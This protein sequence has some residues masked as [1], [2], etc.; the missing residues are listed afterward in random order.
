MEKYCNNCGNFG[1][2]YRQCKHPVL[3]YGIILFNLEKDKEP[4]IV[5]IERKDSISYIEFL[6]GKYQSIYSIDY[7]LLLFSRFTEKE[8]KEVISNDFDT[9][10]RNLWIHTDT[11]NKNVKKEYRNSFEKFNKLKYGFQYKNKLINLNYLVSEIKTDYKMNEWEIPKGRRILKESNKECAIREFEEE[12]NISKDKFNIYSNIAPII[13]EYKGINNIPYKHVYYI[14]KI[15][16]K[17]KVEINLDNKDQYTEVKDIKWV[18]KSEA[19]NNIRN[20][21]NP[22]KKVINDIFTFISNNQNYLFL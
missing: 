13:E 6:R 3:S 15:K 21:D 11:I 4:E 17:I 8:K 20:H 22:K 5:M 2:Y 10:W 19:L 1:H 7:L 16:E 9:L 14:A 12:T 18:N